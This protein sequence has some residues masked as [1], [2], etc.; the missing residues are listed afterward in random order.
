[1]P[2]YDV[3]IVNAS[4]GVSGILAAKCRAVVRA[5][6]RVTFQW[7]VDGTAV[8]GIDS[9]PA[10]GEAFN[11]NVEWV[12]EL[13]AQVSGPAPAAG[14]VC[15][16]CTVPPARGY[17]MHDVDTAVRHGEPGLSM[18]F[19]VAS[20]SVVCTGLE[21]VSTRPE[22]SWTLNDRPIPSSSAWTVR[23]NGGEEGAPARWQSGVRI[24]RLVVPFGTRDVYECVVTLP[25]G[26][27]VRASKHWSN[28]DYLIVQKNGAIRTTA[29][30]VATG[31]TVV[32]ILRL[33]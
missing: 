17:C 26:R 8:P 14:L 32:A 29:L 25:D 1:M 18:R 16:A 12:N 21:D 4:L 20:V 13:H 9:P 5:P 22:F 23:V 28:I 30:S 31:I 15:L 11:G 19:D 27:T 3:Q 2:L 10:R 7:R 33:L 24:A 6:Y